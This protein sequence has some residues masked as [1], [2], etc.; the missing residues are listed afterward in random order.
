MSNSDKLYALTPHEKRDFDEMRR[1]FLR[2]PRSGGQPP[3]ELE[4][5]R[6]EYRPPIIAALLDPLEC[7]SSAL[8]AV[9][10][11][12]S[13]NNIQVITAYGQPGGGH[14]RLGYRASSGAS[15]VWTPLF[16]PMVDDAQKLQRYLMDIVGA[17]NVEVSL[18]LITLPDQTTHNTWRWHIRF[19]GALAGQEIPLLQVEDVLTG[20]AL[21]VQANNPLE[22]TGE[23][24]E[25]FEV[26]GVPNPTPLRAGCRILA[27]WHSGIGYVPYVC[28]I[29]DF[30]DYGLFS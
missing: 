24:E 15:T 23:V 12:L 8:A 26:V 6:D 18:G 1:L 11:K 9:L 28:E 30:N 22:A 29:R 2:R 21:L 5:L 17:G 4:S 13:L 20:S 16:Y 19:G 7:G 3:A 27:Q 14:F 25:I 10:N